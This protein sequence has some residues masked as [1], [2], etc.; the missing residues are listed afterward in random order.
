MMKTIS[1]ALSP[2]YRATVIEKGFEG[3]EF[4]GFSAV[5][6]AQSID[7]DPP[8]GGVD[9]FAAADGLLIAMGPFRLR[10]R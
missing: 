1:F 3:I 8:T 2:Y 4:Y 6:R 10:W 5:G 7:H 9:P